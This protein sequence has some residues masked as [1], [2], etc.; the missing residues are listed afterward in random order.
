MDLPTWNKPA[1]ACLASRF[2]YQSTITAKALECV[3]QA[4]DFIRKEMGFRQVRVRHHPDGGAGVLEDHEREVVHRDEARGD[5]PVAA[6][7]GRAST[8]C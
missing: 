8:S 5:R 4:E 6:T 2:P 1:M 7:G 3:E